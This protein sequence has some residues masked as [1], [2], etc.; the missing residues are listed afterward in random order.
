MDEPLGDPGEHFFVMRIRHSGAPPFIRF[1]GHEPGAPGR[2]GRTELFDRFQCGHPLRVLPGD[3]PVRGDRLRRPVRLRRL[4]GTSEAAQR[5]RADGGH[6]V[7]PGQ[8]L[9][10]AEGIHS[11]QLRLRAI[12]HPDGDSTVER[13][14]RVRP[15]GEETVVRRHDR[16]PVGRVRSR[17]EG[18]LRSDRRLERVRAVRHDGLTGESYALGD[19][20]VVPPL[21]V[22]SFQRD[23]PAVGIEPGG[24]P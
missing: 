10:R 21:P 17:G 1:F 7:V 11:V 6:G 4:A 19:E 16:R 24:A 12:A 20:G 18:V 14:D 13:H 15:Q 5:I 8:L 9:G 22:L 23:Q 2:R 3:R